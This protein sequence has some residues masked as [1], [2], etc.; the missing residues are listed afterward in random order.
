[1]TINEWLRKA[2][3]E[4]NQL[5]INSARLD[6]LLLLES[7]LD[8]DKNQIIA[9][10]DDV[11][12]KANQTKLEQFLKQRSSHVPLAYIVGKKD[13]FG[14]SFI[15]NK[16]VLIPLPETEY[17]VEQASSIA[18]KNA[19][20][21]EIGTG[22]GVIAISLSIER[23][24]I[25]ITATDISAKALKVASQNAKRLKSDVSLSMSDLFSTV[26]TKFDVIIANL[27]YVPIGARRQ[28]EITHEPDI[29]L[30]SGDDGL[31]LY[32]LF[33]AQASNFLNHS[34][35]VL[36]EFSPTQYS[37]LSNFLLNKFSITPIT[38]YIYLCNQL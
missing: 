2:T 26:S 19:T 18:P 36:V 16:D 10:S 12:N 15:V 27:P 29:A 4:L 11:L 6:A 31:D 37:E 20:V 21:L 8:V 35:L 1:M 5:G 38:E 14:H 17:I 32:R 23:N 28:P 24:D 7:V 30:Y 25:S 22:S 33:F 3:R 13:F 34:G 9:H